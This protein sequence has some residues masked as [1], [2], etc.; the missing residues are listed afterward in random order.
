MTDFMTP[1]HY[2]LEEGSDSMDVD[3]SPT[4]NMRIVER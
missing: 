2:V 1:A 3:L 4:E